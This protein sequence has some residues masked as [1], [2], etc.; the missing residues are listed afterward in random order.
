MILKNKVVVITGSSTGIGK[1]AAELFAKEGAK[2]V[3]N[4]KNNEIG[5]KALAAELQKTTE[6]IYVKANVGTRAGARELL[7][8]AVKKF[9]S[10]D[11]LINNAGTGKESAFLVEPEAEMMTLI[12]NNMLSTIFCSQYALELMQKNEGISKIINTSS[13][14]GW[15]YGGNGPVYSATKAA[16]SSL[17]VTLA[18]NF[19]PKVLVN[20]VAP[21]FT[22]TPN[23]EKFDPEVVKSFIEQAKLKRWIHPEEVAE[24]FLFIAKNDAITGEVI[25]VDAGFRLK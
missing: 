5:G 3:L 20:A 21:G 24:T 18:K 19:A 16:V 9:G 7:D 12:E 1:A 2:I 4:S 14:R 10:V 23:Y 17:T 22:E 6:A 15:E 25:Y 11:V 8:A 13:I